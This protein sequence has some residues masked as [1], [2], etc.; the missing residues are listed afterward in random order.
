MNLILYLWPLKLLM[1]YLINF[2]VCSRW[3]VATASVFGRMIVSFILAHKTGSM[4]KICF[5]LLVYVRLFGG[6]TANIFVLLLPHL[7]IKSLFFSANLNTTKEIKFQ[8]LTKILI[9]AKTSCTLFLLCA[10][11]FGGS[12]VSQIP[13]I[14]KI[15]EAYLALGKWTRLIY[16]GFL[17]MRMN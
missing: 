4:Y 6:K 5:F 9:S 17:I 1:V 14:S 2:C 10:T 7:V 3:S 8:I 13:F 12:E 15:I 16:V 11:A